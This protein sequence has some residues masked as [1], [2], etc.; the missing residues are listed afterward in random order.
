MSLNDQ[1]M[2]EYQQNP[3]ILQRWLFL[4]AKLE[5]DPSLL[6]IPL[7]NIERWKAS[8]RLGDPWALEIWR[9]L[10]EQALDSEQGMVKLLTFLTEDG[11]R[12]RQL[13]SCSPFPGVL[14]RK[15]RDRFTCA[16]TL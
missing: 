5:K 15:E 6:K 3:L 13:K 12:A 8:G 16:W 1:A 4:A 11:E 9:G 14:T 7:Q 2:S 10:I